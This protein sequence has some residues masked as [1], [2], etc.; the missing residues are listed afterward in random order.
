MSEQ[1]PQNLVAEFEYKLFYV[2]IMGTPI[3]GYSIVVMRSN[4]CFFTA[5]CGDMDVAQDL[6]R[7]VIG[8]FEERNQ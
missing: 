5:R 2:K 3:L 1:A 7:T 6:A 8:L 4:Q